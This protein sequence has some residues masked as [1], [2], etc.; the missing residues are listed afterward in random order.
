[1]TT[2]QKNVLRKIIYAVET[3]G[4]VYGQQ[5]YSDFTEAYTNSSE[6]HAITIGAGQWYATEAQTLLKRIHDAD[7]EAWDR[8]DNIGLWEQ[9]QEADWSCFNISRNSQFAN[10]IV[11]LISSKI[12]VKCQDSL[13]DE[14]LA[15]YADEALKQGVTDARAQAMCVNFRHQGGLGAVTRILA[16]TQKPYTLDNL[17][18]AC[19]TDTGNQVG[20]YKDRQ[21]FVYD[22]LKTYFPEREETGMN[23]I[24]KLIQIAK[25]EVGYLEKASNSQ[26]DSKTANAGSNNYT[27]YWRDVKPSYQGQPWCAG[28][29]SWCFMKAFGQEKAKEL[30]KHWPYVYCPTLGNLFTK[31]AN[32][33]I[34]D[35]VIFY[36]NGTFTHTGIVT[37]VIGDMFYTIEGNTSGASG[38]IANGGGVCAKSY[39]NSQMPGTKFCTPN[40]SLVKDTTP[41]SDSDTVKKQNTRA[42]IAQIKKDTKCYAKSS[43]NSPSKLFPKL[44]KGAVVEVMKYTE[45]DSAGLKW[46]FVRIPYPNDDGF[47]FEFV[48]K[49]VFTRISEIHK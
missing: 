23:A 2:E 26:L 46:Y 38:I 32:P 43:K 11:Q 35:I 40:Y 15:T 27:K 34:G 14:Q 17:Y 39:L 8:L 19:Q 45:T 36:R 33:K 1:M 25:N 31:N 49:G 44:K 18:A 21:K 29:V 16:K 48:P 22:A 37:A 9:V 4:Q 7:T 20:A 12:G 5:D 3:G 28:F 41:V 24:D 30:L 47:I 13:M 6:E 42:Y 10:L